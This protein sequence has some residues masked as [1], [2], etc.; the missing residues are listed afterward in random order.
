M[1][2]VAEAIGTR[3]KAIVHTETQ[4]GK[5]LID[6]HFAIMMRHVWEFVNSG[7][8]ASTED[9]LVTALRSYGC[10]SNTVVE[11]I[12]HD[13]LHLENYVKANKIGLEKFESAGRHNE[14]MFFDDRI[15]VFEYSGS[16]SSKSI[17]FSPSVNI[18]SE[19]DDLDDMVVQHT[20]LDTHDSLDTFAEAIYDIYSIRSIGCLN[21]GAMYADAEDCI[22]VE[23]PIF[24]GHITG[25][26][27]Y[28]THTARY[29]HRIRT[30]NTM[31]TPCDENILGDDVDTDDVLFTCH[32]FC[33]QFRNDCNLQSHRCIVKDTSNTVV[34]FCVKYAMQCIHGGRLGLVQASSIPTTVDSVPPDLLRDLRHLDIAVHF[35]PLWAIRPPH[36]KAYGKKYIDFFIAD[37]EDIVNRGFR[38]KSKRMGPGKIR[39]LLLS[40]YP[41]R[42]DIPCDTEIQTVI[43]RLVQKYKKHMQIHGSSDEIIRLKKGT[44]SHVKDCFKKSLVEL[45]AG[46]QT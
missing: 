20:S 26:E 41:D 33:R 32:I 16:N 46:I 7:N 12:F 39:P 45:F 24:K 22:N 13:R 6:A 11:L 9:E 35:G 38:D 42:F 25:C 14:V 21:E 5:G 29:R 36:G 15:E 2:L 19:S 17:S 4:D 43:T 34:Q 27:L 18:Q 3:I 28:D 44:R 30:H 8:N 31:A 37:I 40:R 10:V 23:E 1:H